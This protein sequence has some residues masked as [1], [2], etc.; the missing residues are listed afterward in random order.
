MTLAYD[1]LRREREASLCRCGCGQI[2]EQ[3]HDPDS[4][5]RWL[6]EESTCFARQALEDHRRSHKDSPPGTLYAVRLGDP[7]E[8][9]FDPA[10]AAVER[11]ARDARLAALAAPPAD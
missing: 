11:A 6:V 5:G 1:G 7:D 4:E 8:L 9:T 3:S 2:A 10:R